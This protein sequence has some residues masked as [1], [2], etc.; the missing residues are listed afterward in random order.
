[1]PEMP[2]GST[3]DRAEMTATMIG[4]LPTDARV[5]A[6]AEE[7]EMTMSVRVRVPAGPDG[8]AQLAIDMIE[9]E[10]TEYQR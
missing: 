8:D 3:T 2:E 7:E 4:L 1:M 5:D 6:L 10:I 9:R